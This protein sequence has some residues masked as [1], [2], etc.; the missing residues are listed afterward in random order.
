MPF[1]ARPGEVARISFYNLPTDLVG[2]LG[3][4][5]LDGTDE[6][7]PRT[8]AGIVELVEGLGAY[9]VEVV[10]PEPPGVYQV[11][12][13][14]G[15][16]NPG[17]TAVRALEVTRLPILGT[18]PDGAPEWAPTLEQV[19]LVTPAYTRGGFDDDVP[20]A[21][22][23]QGTFTDSTSPT[24]QHVEGLIVTA[25]DEIA[26]RVGVEIP[27]RCHELARTAALWH[28]ASAIA[29]GKLP[30]QT[31]DASGEHRAHS[32]RYLDTLDELVSQARQPRALRVG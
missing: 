16:G 14:D 6:V 7:I 10:A 22:A 19:A 21:G 31:D 32:G 27:A 15:S 8:T 29:A 3:V 11:L 20:Q 4:R 18:T 30:A 28:V 25:C 23:E 5:V 24:A 9:L 1:Y 2:T 12:L 26:A 13:D 17:G